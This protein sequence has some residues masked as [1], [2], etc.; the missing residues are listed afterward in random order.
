MIFIFLVACASIDKINTANSCVI[1]KEKKNLEYGKA[2][3]INS[4]NFHWDKII[5][6]YKTIL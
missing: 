4:Q 2:A 1:F 5:E 3:K 6:N